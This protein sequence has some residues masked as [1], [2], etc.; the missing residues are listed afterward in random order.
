MLG[1]APEQLYRR[2]RPEIE[3]MPWGSL[4]PRA[5]AADAVAE[6][7]LVWTF[8]AFQEHRTGAAC[9]ATLQALITSRAPLDL[10]V[11]AS[12]FPVDEMA[13]VEMCARLAAAL[14]GA[15]ALAYDPDDQV[16]RPPP[17]HR[18][19]LRCAELVVRAFC[20]GEAVSIPLLREAARRAA[21]PL[22]HAVLAR[23]ARD[24]AAHGRF[25]WIYLDWLGAEL[26]DAD[27]AY[28]A[29]CAGSEIG[30]LEGTWQSVV[31]RAEVKGAGEA[32]GWLPNETYLASAHRALDREVK[33]PLAERG[34]H[35]AATA[36]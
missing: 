28:L 33:Q 1:G 9:A 23:I 15:V 34:I 21:H 8:A 25:G 32:L 26:S 11:M 19:A 30:K 13:H 2:L 4:D 18:P 27:R 5:H 3:R 6:A 14:G 17:E 35:V 16:V 24:E 10:V 7:R 31:R 20:V 29:V 22:I 36:P 12:R